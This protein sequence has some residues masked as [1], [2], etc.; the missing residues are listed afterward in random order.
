M[1]RRSYGYS[2]GVYRPDRGSTIQGGLNRMASPWANQGTENPAM[3]SCYSV[4][5]DDMGDGTAA[6]RRRARGLRPADPEGF[7][8]GKRGRR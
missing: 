2:Y 1:A 4:I 6:S 5:V 7:I 3:L 8:Y